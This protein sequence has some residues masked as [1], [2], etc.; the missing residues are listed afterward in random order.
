MDFPMYWKAQILH[1]EL[2]LYLESAT[3][4]AVSPVSARAVTESWT[5]D[6]TWEKRTAAS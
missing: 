5:N 1:A 6:A 3:A 2:G 4:S